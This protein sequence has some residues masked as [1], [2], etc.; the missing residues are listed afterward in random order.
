MDIMST[1]E[2]SDQQ[3]GAVHLEGV[4][5]RYQSAQ[6][7]FTALHEVSL[8]IAPGEHVAIVGRSGSGKS[9]LLNMLTGI[10]RPSAGTVRVAGIELGTLSEGELATFRGR[11]I[12]IVFQFFQ[13]IA[14]LSVRENVLLAMELVDVV[15]SAARESRVQ[16]L[17][18]EVGIADQADE[19]PSSLSG[20]EQQRVAI[21]RALAND[22]ALLVADEP[23]GNLDGETAKAI[24]ALLAELA[25]RGKT[26]VV[27]TH[28]QAVAASC[29]RV[30]TVVDG[31]VS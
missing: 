10:D 16:R 7:A 21:A 30:V 25:R 17:L 8:T 23:T 14:T 31:R 13:L 9:T 5:R 3:A 27:V 12:G 29:S 18:E 22:P 11:H 24:C 28:D 1:T 4:T 26:V 19:L 2:Q 15:P 20:G 6:R